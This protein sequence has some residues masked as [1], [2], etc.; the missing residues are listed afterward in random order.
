MDRAGLVVLLWEQLWNSLFSLYQSIL[1]YTQTHLPFTVAQ[2]PWVTFLPEEIGRQ[3]SKALT[4]CSV[5]YD[6]VYFYLY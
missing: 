6:Y 4:S 5:I 2:P 1:S 3:Q